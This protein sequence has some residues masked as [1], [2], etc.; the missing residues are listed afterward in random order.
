[1]GGQYR[2]SEIGGGELHS[3]L[4]IVEDR[5]PNVF[6]AVRVTYQQIPL[7]VGKELSHAAILSVAGTSQIIPPPLPQCRA[8]KK[9]LRVPQ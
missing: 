9:T 3:L 5:H 1:M 7:G 6:C 2:L 8:L 4:D